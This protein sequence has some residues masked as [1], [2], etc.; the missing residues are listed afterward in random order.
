VWFLPDTTFFLATHEGSQVW[1]VDAGGIAHVFL[2]GQ[3]GDSHHSGD[4][5]NYRTLGL[6]VSEVRAVTV[7]YQGNVIVTENDCGYIRKVSKRNSGVLLHS[8]FNRS[9]ANT[10]SVIFSS[11]TIILRFSLSTHTPVEVW[12]VDVHGRIQKNIPTHSVVS[13][14]HEIRIPQAILPP[15][16]YFLRCQHQALLPSHQFVVLQ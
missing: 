10:F 14:L 13:G 11:R 8:S 3:S 5:E 7:D 15:G 9:G 6:K 16:V 2:D 12:I 4:N 1:H